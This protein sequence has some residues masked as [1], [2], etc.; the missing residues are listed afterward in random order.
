M[1]APY[2]ER[3]LVVDV[4]VGGQPDTPADI[5]LFDTFGGRRHCLERA[6]EMVNAR[7]VDRVVL[8][9]WDAAPEFLADARDVGVAAVV[10]KACGAEELVSALERIARHPATMALEPWSAP[11]ETASPLLTRRQTEVL[12]LLA[13]GLTNAQIGA[14]LYLGTETVRTYVAQVFRKLGVR[15]RTE[16]AATAI[17]QGLG[18]PAGSVTVADAVTMP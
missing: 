7:Q 8:Y 16:A 9:T 5:A 15:N 3:V 1:L 17:Q 2:S 11:R 4:E 12:A 10:S 13:Q 6:R 18:R 14:E